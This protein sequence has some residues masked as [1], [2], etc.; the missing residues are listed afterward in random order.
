MLFLFIVTKYG[1]AVKR[2]SF[3]SDPVWKCHAGHL[4]YTQHTRCVQ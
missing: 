3:L 1:F 2:R 4:V